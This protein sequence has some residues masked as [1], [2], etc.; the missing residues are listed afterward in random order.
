MSQPDINQPSLLAKALCIGFYLLLPALLACELLVHKH[1]AFAV[2][3]WYGFYA[4]YGLLTALLV[5]LIANYLLRPF[6]RRDED[7]YDR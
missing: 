3:E 7:Y 1:A 5:V 4:T 6:T 2:E